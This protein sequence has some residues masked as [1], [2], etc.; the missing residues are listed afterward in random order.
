MSNVEKVVDTITGRPWR[1][2]HKFVALI[3]LGMMIQNP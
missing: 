3:A 1:Q 2:L